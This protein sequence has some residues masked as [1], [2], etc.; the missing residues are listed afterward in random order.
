M[1]KAPEIKAKIRNTRDR[2]PWVLD[3]DDGQISR[4]LSAEE[5]EELAVPHSAAQPVRRPQP[6][7]SAEQTWD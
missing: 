1:G 4:E 6:I 3:S 2:G 5:Q 7:Q